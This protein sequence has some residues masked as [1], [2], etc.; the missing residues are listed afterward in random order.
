MFPSSS[1]VYQLPASFLTFNGSVHIL[2]GIPI[3]PVTDFSNF[4]LFKYLSKPILVNGTLLRLSEQNSLLA[5]SKD[6]SSF[7][8]IS[9]SMIHSCLLLGKSFLCH[10]LSVVI[11]DVYPSCL[12]SVFSS[13]ARGIFESC[14][15]SFLRSRFYLERLNATS[16]VSFTKV[17]TVAIR[18]CNGTVSQVHL[19][20]YQI[21]N[22]SPGC[23]LHAGGVTFYSAFTPSVHSDRVITEFPTDF[24][25]GIL[26]LIH[27]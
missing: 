12:R 21:V 25:L 10:F 6:K 9:D 20:S 8:E 7:I 23:I 13:D 24:T 17:S 15:F 18:T 22:L 27:I 16:F 19:R 3:V 26:S 2:V 11:S 5:I 14:S 1:Q 4:G